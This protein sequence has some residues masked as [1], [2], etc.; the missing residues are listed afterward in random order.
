MASEAN[1][2]GCVWGLTAVYYPLYHEGWRVPAGHDRAAACAT[3]AA[4]VAGSFVIVNTSVACSLLFGGRVQLAGTGS[5]SSLVD[6]CGFFVGPSDDV[7]VRAGG[8]A[9]RRWLACLFGYAV[10]AGKL[11]QYGAPVSQLLGV[12]EHDLPRHSAPTWRLAEAFC[13]RVVAERRTRSGL[14]AER[15]NASLYT[16]GAPLRLSPA[17]DRALDGLLS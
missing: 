15:W 7:D 3:A 13:R 4:S 10:F 14:Y 17:L 11:G 12:C 9:W 1:V 2:R 16:L 5:R 8:E 6:W